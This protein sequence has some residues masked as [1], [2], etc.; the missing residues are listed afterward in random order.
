MLE[1]ERVTVRFGPR[2][3]L[4][5]VGLTVDDREVVAVLGP[6]G[7]GK[8]TLLRVIA[9]LHPPDAG[10]VCW[11]G[12]DLAGVPAHQRRFGLV[13]QDYQLFPH[14]DVAANIAFGLRM[15]HR[16]KAEI[17]ARVAGLLEMVGLS[18]FDHRRVQDLSG[19]E[20]QRVALARALAP[21]PRL[22]LLDEPLGA[23]D[24]D[25]HDRLMVDL[26][27]LLRELHMTA[28]HVTHDRDEATAIADRIIELPTPPA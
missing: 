27:D 28:V 10:R 14:R 25:L 19:G 13:F 2:T 11:D 3:V 26:H 21:Q 15:Q 12:T 22:L 1:V 23:L 6:S 20:Q 18:G 16:P 9:G 5:A 24:R 17:A 8:S 7:C 4:D